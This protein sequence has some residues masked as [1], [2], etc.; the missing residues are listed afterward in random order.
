M[1]LLARYARSAAIMIPRQHYHYIGRLFAFFFFAT[2][3]MRHGPW[4]PSLDLPLLSYIAQSC[5]NSFDK[6][7]KNCN[8]VFFLV[9]NYLNILT[10]KS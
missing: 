7:K 3:N 5:E 10:F 4:A 8:D 2:T 9:V 6:C 1:L